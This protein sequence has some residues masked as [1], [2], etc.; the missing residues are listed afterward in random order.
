MQNTRDNHQTLDKKQVPF[1]LTNK[2]MALFERIVE[3]HLS[4]ETGKPLCQAGDAMNSIYIVLSGS[5]EGTTQAEETQQSATLYSAGEVIG[6]DSLGQRSH[7]QT[8]V[9]REISEVCELPLDE[10]EALAV[11]MPSLRK[12][13]V[14]LLSDNIQNN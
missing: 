3:R 7:K 14:G 4:C 2:E 10:L 8:V 5:F 11:R 13:F 12:Q 6:L 9:A 1:T